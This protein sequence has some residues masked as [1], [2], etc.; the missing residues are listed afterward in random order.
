[1][2]SLP[3]R[4]RLS[5]AE[6]DCIARAADL[7]G[8]P[9]V[10][11]DG[12]AH[13][14]DGVVLDGLIA[15]G[16][17]TRSTGE[18][19]LRDDLATFLGAVL[20][21]DASLD[22][23]TS[24]ASGGF[25]AVLHIANELVIA[26]RVEEGEVSFAVVLP[27]QLPIVLLSLCADMPEPAGERHDEQAVRIESAVLDAAERGDRDV[28]ELAG[29][30]T[31][32]TAPQRTGVAMVRGTLYGEPRASCAWVSGPAGTYVVRH[33]GPHAEIVRA[34]GWELVWYLLRLV[35]PP[36]VAPGVTA[37]R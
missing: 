6:L 9:G 23:R 24:D 16:L 11:V 17:I 21:C 29:Y 8:F 34:D 32:A 5:V 22:I 12:D 13:W 7:A 37:G 10:P 20:A 3:T 25:A 19:A 18:P 1:M 26:Q 36:A 14:D 28:P 2:V 30:V 4:L 33:D 31:S 27:H 35:G 15:R